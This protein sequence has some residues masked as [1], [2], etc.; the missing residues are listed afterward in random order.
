MIDDR[1][2]VTPVNPPSNATDGVSGSIYL[3][4]GTWTGMTEGDFEVGGV[5][6]PPNPP[7]TYWGLA[8]PWSLTLTPS[9]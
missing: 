3:T 5:Y 1:G 4:V 2:N 6:G 8:C 9:K 7:G